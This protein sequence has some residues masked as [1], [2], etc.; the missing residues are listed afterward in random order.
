MINFKRK[1]SVIKVATF[2]LRGKQVKEFNEMFLNVEAGHSA[3]RGLWELCPAWPACRDLL[4]ELLW[5]K[6]HCP[7]MAPQSTFQGRWALAGEGKLF[8]A[9]CYFWWQHSHH[10]DSRHWM[11]TG[12]KLSVLAICCIFKA[13]INYCTEFPGHVV[14]S[15]LV[16][17]LKSSF[18]TI[19]RVV[20]PGAG[21]RDV[22]D[23]GTCCWRALWRIRRTSKLV[24][25]MTLSS[26]LSNPRL[27]SQPPLSFDTDILFAFKLES[28]CSVSMGS[29]QC[30]SVTI[31]GCQKDSNFS[32]TL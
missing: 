21:R 23:A 27:L 26:L 22:L 9:H 2:Q 15:L 1:T 25:R 20:N 11:G 19:Q 4:P 31:S 3:C 7:P 13:I 5:G 6:K 16:G 32:C 8:L 30:R 10:S 29:W 28:L 24:I 12:L 17:I 18:V 14:D